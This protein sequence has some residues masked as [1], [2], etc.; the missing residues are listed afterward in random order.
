MK[1]RVLQVE[2]TNVFVELTKENITNEINKL[3]DINNKLKKLRKILSLCGNEKTLI[4]HIFELASEHSIFSLIKEILNDK[5]INITLKQE[6]ITLFFSKIY[7]AVLEQPE[8]NI[9][10]LDI[11]LEFYKNEKQLDLSKEHSSHYFISPKLVPYLLKAAILRG[12]F[13]NF[14]F[15]TK[16]VPGEEIINIVFLSL[17]K[18][19]YSSEEEKPRIL[20]KRLK[21][22]KSLIKLNKT[23]LY[24]LDSIVRIIGK[25]ITETH[26][27]DLIVKLHNEFK[28]D[29]RVE[30]K[31]KNNFSLRT[32]LPELIKTS[33]ITLDIVLRLKETLWNYPN[34]LQ[35][36]FHYAL[37]LGK[38]GE[39][40]ANEI[41]IYAYKNK[42]LFTQNKIFKCAIMLNNHEI[43]SDLLDDK[44]QSLHLLD[45]L[46][47]AKLLNNKSYEPHI[48]KAI[49]GK[50]LGSGFLGSNIDFSSFI[51]DLF[52]LSL[53][54]NLPNSYKFLIEHYSSHVF[55]KLATS[56][57]VELNTILECLY[58]NNSFDILMEAAE[59]GYFNENNLSTVNSIIYCAIRKNISAEWILEFF[60]T[61]KI[62]ELNSIV[63][64]YI[65]GSKT[66]IYI[67][68]DYILKKQDDYSVIATLF[69]CALESKSSELI[70]LISTTS[71]YNSIV[72]ENG[73]DL[74][75]KYTYGCYTKMF[76]YNEIIDN[77]LNVYNITQKPELDEEEDLKNYLYLIHLSLNKNISTKL[78]N[79]LEFNVYE[80]LLT[81]CEKRYI[82]DKAN[83]YL[84]KFIL[85]HDHFQ[86]I[87][88]K[89]QFYLTLLNKYLNF[90]KLNENSLNIRIEEVHKILKKLDLDDYK[91]LIIECGNK[92]IDN[93]EE[94]LNTYKA[95]FTYNK[96]KQLEKSTAFIII[97]NIC[98][99]SKYELFTSKWHIHFNLL[100][101]SQLYY[102]VQGNQKTVDSNRILHEVFEGIQTENF[103]LSEKN[104]YVQLALEL[105]H[106]LYLAP[107][108]KNNISKFILEFS[109]EALAAII[110]IA[111]DDSVIIH[112][113][114]KNNLFE[115]ISNIYP[116]LE[117]REKLLYMAD[118]LSDK[119]FTFFLN[120]FGKII[121][122]KPFYLEFINYKLSAE[123]LNLSKLINLISSIENWS[124]YSAEEICKFL[125]YKET[126][127]KNNIK[128]N[129]EKV[130][131]SLSNE[132]AL[133]LYNYA[134]S[135]PV[136][137]NFIII[138]KGIIKIKSLSNND[139]FK[140]FN[141]VLKNDHKEA[142][143]VLKEIAPNNFISFFKNGNA[144][145]LSDIEKLL[146]E[147]YEY[148]KLDCGLPDISHSRLK[149]EYKLLDEFK[150]NEDVLKDWFI[151]IIEEKSNSLCESNMFLSPS[152]WTIFILSK[153]T[154]E[155]LDNFEALKA[156]Y[157][158]KLNEKLDI[159]KE[160]P[161]NYY[162]KVLKAFY[163]AKNISV[164]N[165]R[166][167]CGYYK[168]FLLLECVMRL[169]NYT[170][171]API[172]KKEKQEEFKGKIQYS[173]DKIQKIKMYLPSNN[174]LITLLK[175]LT[176]AFSSYNI[177]QEIS[178]TIWSYALNTS[179][180]LP[181]HDMKKVLEVKQSDVSAEVINT[182]ESFR[183]KIENRNFV[184][185][186]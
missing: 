115:K 137:P 34:L 19:Y 57:Q 74:Y 36:T 69:E 100:S 133:K 99:N 60:N 49:Y 8:G 65:I 53:I 21:S 84:Y 11:I 89:S 5:K 136:N 38:E 103:E 181:L 46:S 105:E 155:A 97:K 62:N 120:V 29:F 131:K 71:V 64:D 79:C 80:K 127:E 58:K 158:N 93:Q 150:D 138:L 101:F 148:L 126:L 180:E 116:S 32:Y 24:C 39:K 50:H 163:I 48:K 152:L 164:I 140:F 106:T 129:V 82:N 33:V 37:E 110:K 2:G 130:L 92:Y 143:W 144:I 141:Y 14:S 108:I 63:V 95:L 112:L 142:L 107:E 26:E 125:N 35:E 86:K 90:D 73:K 146:R 3:S 156:V 113:L 159:I 173:R 135:Q 177:P 17:S 59:K 109:P 77:I 183:E 134:L 16:A 27:L 87:D 55:E 168:S 157:F 153:T 61:S 18:K 151:N 179:D 72:I 121:N 20:E 149:L 88:N 85:T 162:K 117:I 111:H 185:T 4:L 67:L 6:A 114:A 165:E 96:F 147:V 184:I 15:L 83:F 56:Y 22:F 182:L 132:A 124:F 167:K 10:V 25:I 154:P 119:K 175:D 40:L 169:G 78:L 51:F 7:K 43:L 174:L 23:K 160:K 104:V 68:S 76:E 102:Q 123:K 31:F 12:K 186:K 13:E 45:N 1:K 172:F 166:Y 170:I 66:P 128:I 47:L 145:I 9:E 54:H 176:K 44:N 42:L 122:D 41:L 171:T 118:N 91:N 81:L 178:F 75:E 30:E 139:K 98:L 52:H 28:N 70:K 94:Y 161:A